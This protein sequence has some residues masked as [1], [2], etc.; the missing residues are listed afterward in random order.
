MGVLQAMRGMMSTQAAA[1]A[2]ANAQLADMQRRALEAEE[3]NADT[4]MD[5]DCPDTAPGAITIAAEGSCFNFIP[6]DNL[7]QSTW[8]MDLTGVT[9]LFDTLKIS[10]V[11]ELGL[12]KCRL[13]P[14]SLGKLAEYVRDADAALTKID[15]RNNTLDA[16]SLK[17]LKVAAPQGCEILCD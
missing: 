9:A 2:A 10:S 3:A 16:D 6:D 5:G 13:G 8:S 14:G 1:M 7:A 17:T 15:V 12:A 4:L 11:T